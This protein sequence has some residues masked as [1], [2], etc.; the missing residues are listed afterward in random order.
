ME[1]QGVA[2]LHGA[3][4]INGPHKVQ[5]SDPTPQAEAWMGVDELDISQ[6][7]DLV[8]RVSDL[9]DIRADRVAEVRAEIAAGVYE[10]DEKLDIALGRLLDEISG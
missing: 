4:P 2:H 7:A 5:A 8:D 1:I 3:Q 6:E 10:T 9:P